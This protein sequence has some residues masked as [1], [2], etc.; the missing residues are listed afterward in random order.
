M[1]FALHT[2][3]SCSSQPTTPTIEAV[4]MPR[5]SEFLLSQVFA[6]KVLGL[7]L[8]LLALA[9]WWLFQHIM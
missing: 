1:Y 3:D 7:A 9:V 8:L 6:A 5:E 4:K 2:E